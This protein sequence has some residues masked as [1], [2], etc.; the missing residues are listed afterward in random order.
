MRIL[1]SLFILL[2]LVACNQGTDSANNAWNSQNNSNPEVCDDGV[3][4]DGDGA[5]DCNDSDCWGASN[6]L[7]NNMNNT[8]NVVQMFTLRGKVWA[9]G[10]DNTATHPDNIMPIPGALVAAYL[11]APPEIPFCNECVDV[12]VGVRHVFSDTDGSFEL[13]LIPNTTYFLV[14]QKGHFRRVTQYTAGEPDGYEDFEENVGTAKDS[15]ATLPNKHDP[16]N[17]F[18]MPRILV[19]KGTYNSIDDMSVVFGALGFQWQ[20]ALGQGNIDAVNDYGSE[21]EAIA[22]SIDRLKDY[23]L[24]IFTCGG[25]SDFLTN[26]TYRNNM[27][28]Y[29]YEGGKLYVDDFA[30]DWAEQPFPEFLTFANSGGSDC[31]GGTV[32]PSSVGDCNIYSSYDPT[33]TAGD[34]YLDLWL[35]VINPGGVIELELAYDIIK[36]MGP[37]IQGL[38]DDDSDPNCQNGIYTAPPKVWMYGTWSGYTMQP[39]TVSWNYYCGKVLYTTYHTEGGAGE[40]LLMLQEKIMFYLIMEMNTCTGPVV[41]E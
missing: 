27:R 9:P 41:V 34:P 5:A 33:G 40:G 14:V 38:C 8:N 23:N 21:I 7:N 3:D 11:S 4:N 36:S 16:A 18:Y 29:V 19:V 32:A 22:G 20:E 1:T 15:R 30:Y 17:G 31:A 35:D 37:G 10:G 13:D 2:F 12:P 39:V 25:G 28:Q 6:C 24:I 26:A